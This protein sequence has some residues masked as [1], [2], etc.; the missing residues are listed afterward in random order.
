MVWQ[1]IDRLTAEETATEAGAG[2]V[3]NKQLC[4]AIGEQC[5]L[6]PTRQ[7]ALLGALHLVQDQ[8]GRLSD[9]AM[10]EVAELLELSPA[11]VLDTASFYDM[12]H[13]EGCGRH[14]IGVCESLSCELCGSAELLTALK[15]KLGIEPGQTTADGK[16]TLVTMQCLGACDFAPAMLI[17]RTLYKTVAPDELDGIL[18]QVDA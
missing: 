2:P 17:D 12:F 3:L 18:Q 8:L 1:S 11:E 5:K 6:Y 13:R 7:A 16:Y 4:M 15:E 10:A 14:I 9:R